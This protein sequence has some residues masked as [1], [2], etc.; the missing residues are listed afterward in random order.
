MT[1]NLANVHVESIISPSLEL[2]S[3]DSPRRERLAQAWDLSSSLVW[4]N[5]PSSWTPEQASFDGSPEN[6]SQTLRLSPHL[7]QE[8]ATTRTLTMGLTVSPRGEFAKSKRP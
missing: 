4:S 6:V 8:L 1:N 3:E 2:F 5:C 7:Y